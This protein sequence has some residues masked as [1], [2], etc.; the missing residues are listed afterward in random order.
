MARQPW[1]LSE[2][3]AVELMRGESERTSIGDTWSK[4]EL[5]Q[6]VVVISSFLGLS[7]FVLGCGISPE[8]DMRGGYFIRGMSD[9]HLDGVEYELSE[10]SPSDEEARKAAAIAT[11]WHD[12]H[13]WSNEKEI[14]PPDQDVGVGLGIRGRDSNNSPTHGDEDDPEAVYREQ[15]S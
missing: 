15:T 6:A 1:R 12:S 9:D 13:I 2:D 4:G 14:F 8:L 10:R 3:D 7:S 5:V 11:G